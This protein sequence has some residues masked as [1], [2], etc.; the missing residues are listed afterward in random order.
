MRSARS[1]GEVLPRLNNSHASATPA[2]HC[3]HHEIEFRVLRWKASAASRSSRPGAWNEGH[4]AGL[5]DFLGACFVAEHREL[6]WRWA[7]K[8]DACRFA[9]FGEMALLT[10]EPIP[11]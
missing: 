5:R 8:S 2:V 6:S 3:F 1:L 7:N 9:S 11:G 4:I 10:E